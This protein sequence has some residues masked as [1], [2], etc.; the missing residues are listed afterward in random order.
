MNLLK[1]P[2]LK[3]DKN[4]KFLID[5]VNKLNGILSKFDNTLTNL[6][7]TVDHIEANIDK[8]N[9]NYVKLIEAEPMALTGNNFKNNS[10]IIENDNGYFVNVSID[11]FP[12]QAKLSLSSNTQLC[13][14]ISDIKL[15]NHQ[16]L[17]FIT[18]NADV[19][20]VYNLTIGQNNIIYTGD[21]GLSCEQYKTGKIF[22]TIIIE[23]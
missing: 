2:N 1:L 12:K 21:N 9:E 18:Y 3:A 13:R 17:Q 22:G 10:Y 8:I 11:I 5:L 7:Y 6:T 16:N 4:N 15:T 19:T 14:L 20:N 23:K